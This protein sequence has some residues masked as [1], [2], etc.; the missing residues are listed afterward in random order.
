MIL[1][2]LQL[3][4]ITFNLQTFFFDPPV[5]SNVWSIQLA[6]SGD[7][8]DCENGI[9]PDRSC[10]VKVTFNPANLPDTT[11]TS[12]VLKVRS[13][14]GKYSAEIILSGSKAPPPPAP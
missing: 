8:V 3:T 2:L 13:E 14:D 6:A 4:I 1:D 9:S 11:P 10:V 7:E 5:N 12:A